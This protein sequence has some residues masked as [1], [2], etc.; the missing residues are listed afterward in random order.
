[1]QNHTR[2]QKS[3]T[4]QSDIIFWHAKAK[5][6]SRQRVERWSK[7]EPNQIK[8]SPPHDCTTWDSSRIGCLLFGWN[9]PERLPICIRYHVV[10]SSHIDGQ[11]TYRILEKSDDMATRSAGM[12]FCWYFDGNYEVITV[13]LIRRRDTSSIHHSSGSTLWGARDGTAAAPCR[14][15]VECW[16]NINIQHPVTTPVKKGFMVKSG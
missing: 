5:I 4:H 7:S 15:V 13:G 3:G 16:T 12:L 1:M 9:W 6:T 14:E 2:S 8:F 11:P 10:I